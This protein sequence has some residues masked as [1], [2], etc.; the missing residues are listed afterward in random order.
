MVMA[1]AQARWTA[2]MVHELPDDGNRYEVV[3]GVLLVSPAPTWP[4]QAACRKLFLRMHAYIAAYAIGEAI[5]APADVE[6]D[7]R[8]MVE[9][10]LFVVPLVAGRAPRS[11]QEA[12]RL[13]LAIEVLSPRTK[14]RDRGVKRRLYQSQGVPEYWI[15]DLDARA[16]ECWRPTDDHPTMRTT[17]LR[18]QPAVGVPPLEIDLPAYF[19]D[20]L[21]A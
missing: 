1:S 2:E 8:N 19:A 4:H 12:E 9:P 11:W 18:W 15:V 20:V 6:F 7:D 17:Q 21:G 13:V 16:F 3:G 10:D 14:R 5:L